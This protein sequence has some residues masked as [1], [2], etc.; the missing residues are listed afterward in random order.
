MYNRRSVWHFNRLTDGDLAAVAGRSDA[1]IFC[2]VVAKAS[3][4]FLSCC[5]IKQ[6]DSNNKEAVYMSIESVKSY[7]NRISTDENFYRQVIECKDSEKRMVFVKAAGFDFTVDEFRETSAAMS[8]D[9]LNSVTGGLGS[10]PGPIP[11][12]CVYSSGSILPSWVG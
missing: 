2:G 9:E 11:A 8:D 12:N 4:E 5:R 1:S 3:K 10:N 6:C 7:I